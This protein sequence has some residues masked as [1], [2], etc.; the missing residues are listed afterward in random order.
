M[1]ISINKD[2]KKNYN[3]KQ[4]T[5]NKRKKNGTPQKYKI[6]CIYQH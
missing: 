1:D 6:T 3:M 4:V 5:K 2:T